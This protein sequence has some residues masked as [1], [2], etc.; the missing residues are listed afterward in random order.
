LG[1][2]YFAG[3]GVGFWKNKHEIEINHEF[4]KRYYPQ[5][6]PKEADKLYRGWQ[7]PPS[8]PPAFSKLKTDKFSQSR[9]RGI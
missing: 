7:K 8:R 2:G 5:M 3:L 9:R 6:D 4:A 1:A